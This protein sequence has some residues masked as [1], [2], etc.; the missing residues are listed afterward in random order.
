[1]AKFPR[2]MII[3]S[4]VGAVIGGAVILKDFIVGHG[5]KLPE[6]VRADGKVCIVTGSNTG[7][8]KETAMELA[9]RGCTVYMACR[10]LEKCRK[11]RAE[12]ISETLNQ[13]V[14]CRKCDLADFDSIRQFVQEFKG[15]KVN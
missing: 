13:H 7:I 11:A 4:G 14:H 2:F 6:T 10:D 3:T 9:K 1:M 15:K 5:H 12:I 8:G